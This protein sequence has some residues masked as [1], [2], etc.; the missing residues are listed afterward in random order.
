MAGQETGAT[1]IVP[2]NPER[3]VGVLGEVTDI[4]QQ[5]RYHQGVVGAVADR[6]RRALQTVLGDRD[7]LAI[8]FLPLGD[9]QFDEVIADAG[10]GRI[11]A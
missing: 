9:E 4:V 6:Q 11:L 1:D 2:V 3:V 10:H 7:I 8:G 5:R